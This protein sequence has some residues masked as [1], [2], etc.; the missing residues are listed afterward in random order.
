M[1][2]TL[3]EQF[4][5]AKALKEEG[6]QLFKAG[7]HANAVKKY[8]RVRAFLRPMMPAGETDEDNSAFINMISQP[9]DNS[10]LTPEDIK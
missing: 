3:R 5:H 4:L 1:P 10:K 7:D 9:D 8:S 2:S 6:N